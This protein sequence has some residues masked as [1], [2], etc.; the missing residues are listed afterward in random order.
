MEST[1]PIN[2]LQ[3][4]INKNLLFA[5]QKNTPKISFKNSANYVKENQSYN[6]KTFSITFD[7][8][9]PTN[10]TT[11]QSWRFPKSRIYYS[12][13]VTLNFKTT[14]I[15]FFEETLI[16][17]QNFNTKEKHS[18]IIT[19]QKN[20]AQFFDLSNK[21]KPVTSK[22]EIN[23]GEQVILF[24]SEKLKTAHLQ[25]NIYLEKLFENERKIHPLSFLQS[26]NN[27][28]LMEIDELWAKIPWI[29]NEGNLSF[30]YDSQRSD[31]K[32]AL[33]FLREL[34]YLF[35]NHEEINN[36][37][38]QQTEQDSFIKNC[39]KSV[40]TNQSLKEKDLS[41][42]ELL[43]TK[44]TD[45]ILVKNKIQ[46][47]WNALSYSSRNLYFENFVKEFPEEASALLI[48]VFKNNFWWKNKIAAKFET[49]L[50]NQN[51]PFLNLYRLY[52]KLALNNFLIDSSKENLKIDLADFVLS[53]NLTSLANNIINYQVVKKR[54]KN[55]CSV[56][57]KNFPP[58]RIDKKASIEYSK[59]DL[60]I[61]KPFLYHH[62]LI[63]EN[64]IKISYEGITLKIILAWK[65]FTVN[66]GDLRLKFLFKGKRYQVS[67]KGAKWINDCKIADIDYSFEK[68]LYHKTYIDVP[69]TNRIEEFQF[70]NSNG[71][72]L[73]LSN[74]EKS[75]TDLYLHGVLTNHY[76][77]VIDSV[78]VNFNDSKKNLNIKPLSVFPDKLRVEKQIKVIVP[79]SY[80]FSYKTKVQDLILTKIKNTDAQLLSQ[81]LVIFIKNPEKEYKNI[82]SLFFKYFGFYVDI[83]DTKHLNSVFYK[84]TIIIPDLVE[85]EVLY[86]SVNHKEIL[87]KNHGQRK[88]IVVSPDKVEAWL[89][90][91]F[92]LS[93]KT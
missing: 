11:T 53:S 49:Q 22:I 61:L 38:K 60:I 28:L 29:G 3:N 31:H 81:E 21:I 12:E 30:K 50:E 85:G 39:L 69:K 63:F 52:S 4:I 2:D 20:K 58:I 68:S 10:K 65:N 32:M 14:I 46:H 34:F 92:E 13:I 72:V 79:K 78:S 55:F 88:A 45:N 9:N 18:L 76:N 37:L 35:N 93:I 56:S 90:E 89:N 44:Q 17:Y 40:T 59:N 6:F 71:T 64:F 24:N 16:V 5:Y 87:L 70:F 7:K 86:T 91:H 48:L 67:I 51:S 62:D 77:H 75:N 1:T 41:F 42:C 80:T 74:L 23:P 33:L 26:E 25:L 57:F 47:S 73:D 66:F 54:D 15:E 83:I 43:S 36:L 8:S 82:K 19:A 84:Y 27:E